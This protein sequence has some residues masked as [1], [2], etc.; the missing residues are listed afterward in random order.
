MISDTDDLAARNGVSVPTH[1]EQGHPLN[2][3]MRR[4]LLSRILYTKMRRG[5][6]VDIDL[7]HS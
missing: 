2:W 5:E 3:G 6:E 1:D 7:D 4:M